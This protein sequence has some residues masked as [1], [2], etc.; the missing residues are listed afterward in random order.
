MRTTDTTCL[1]E[2]LA[3]LALWRPRSAETDLGI[4]ERFVRREFLSSGEHKAGQATALGR[5]LEF[6]HRHVAYYR[7]LFQAQSLEPGE[8]R[9]VTDLPRL[10]V[11][12]KADVVKH[13]KALKSDWLPPGEGPPITAK[14]TGTTGTPVTV[15]M[16]RSGT[17][18]FGLL[19]HR[20]ARWFRYD[21]AGRFAKIRLPSTMPLSA[22]KALPPGSALRRPCWLYLGRHF[23]TGPE[24]S[25]ST[26]N[27]AEKQVAWLRRFRPDYL[28]AYPGV[29]EELSLACEGT[30]PV[31]SLKSLL[32][33][34]ATATPAMRAHIEKTY[35]VPFEQ[36][37]GLNELGLV[38]IRCGAGRY[39][40]NTEHCLV[41]IADETGQPCLPAKTGHLLVTSLQ[42]LAMPLIRYDTGD[43]AQAVEGPCSCGRTLPSFGEIAGRF[44]R[45]AG[46]PEGTRQRVS[47]LGDA[48]AA[49]PRELT[50]TLR[51]HQIYQDRNNRFAVRVQ[52]TGPLPPEFASRLQEAW[53]RVAEGLPLTV[54]GGEP[55]TESPGGKVL[56]FDSEFYAESDRNSLARPGTT[57]TLDFPPA[58]K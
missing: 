11:L 35:Q 3:E 39:H 21:P 40:V 17:Q 48:L 32:G 19:W 30:P 56:D 13:A 52:T 14:S 58:T 33:I 6:A 12:T 49:M 57:P 10:P 16:S 2:E 29:F 7:E 18:M 55:I 1:Q 44:R 53:A 15:L 42:N 27:P 23:E 47:V 24:L 43:I 8:I 4:F 46:L 45:Y 22:G 50:R 37:Y 38:A 5:M 34:G 20:Q 51:R 25:F 9:G 41:E 28:L 36:N 54:S 26:K 31:D